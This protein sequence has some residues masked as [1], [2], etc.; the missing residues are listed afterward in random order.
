MLKPRSQ[1]NALKP[2]PAGNEK[3]EKLA[4][5]QVG[6]VGL[7][8]MGSRMA[9]RLVGA[10]LEIIAFDIDP[11][12]VAELVARGATAAH[13]LRE[14]ADRAAI[15]LCSLPRPD[16]V[17]RAILGENG[18]AGG[19]AVELIIDLS[20]TGTLKLKEIAVA[21]AT[22]GID[23]VDAPVSGGVGGAAAGTLTLMIAG[24]PEARNRVDALLRHLGSNLFII[25]DTPGLGQ[26]MKLVNNMLCAANAVVAFE[27]MV[28][29]VKG[30]L[31]AQTM[32]DVINVSSGR[33]FITTDKLP[34]CVLPRSF[35]PRFAT[36]LLLK[37]LKLAVDEAEA[38]SAP[39]WMMPAALEFIATAMDEGNPQADYASL[40]KYFERRSQVEVT[41]RTTAEV[42]P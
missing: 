18:L 3:M 37:D 31:D 17:E 7:G 10:G 30:G 29:G 38:D 13:T 26:K 20:T 6:F 21:L 16:V 32:L 14:V 24:K 1:A 40:I 42:K 11:A 39:L 23:L 4:M 15:I 12:A 5:S 2:R 28:M 19:S 25:G 9:A 27:A 8:Q 36:E 41:G 22:K 34:Q 35:P 33:S